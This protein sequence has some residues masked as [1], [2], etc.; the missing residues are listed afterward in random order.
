MTV[1]IAVLRPVKVILAE[2][3]RVERTYYRIYWR[4]PGKPDVTTW[5]HYKLARARE[6]ARVCGAADI[7]VEDE[8][9]TAEPAA[10]IA[11]LTAGDIARLR[12][13]EPGKQF[14]APRRRRA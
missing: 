1:A 7:L 11:D 10:R 2:S 4:V 14:Q 5:S 13:G 9:T 6:L 8:V 12:Q 3:R